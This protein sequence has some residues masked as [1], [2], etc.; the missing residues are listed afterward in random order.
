MDITKTENCSIEARSEPRWLTEKE[1]AKITGISV[2][3]LRAHRFK[4]KGIPYSKFE[5]SVRYSLSDIETFMLQNK[6]NF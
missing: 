1:V 5:K 3:T 6:V 2:S 4:H